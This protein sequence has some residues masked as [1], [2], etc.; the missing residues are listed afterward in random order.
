VLLSIHG[1]PAYQ[2]RPLYSMYNGL[3]QYLL[4]HGIAVLA[5]NIRGSAGYGLTYRQAVYRDWGGVDL[6]DLATVARYLRGQ[7][8][9]D[10]DRI[11]LLGASYGGFAVLSC[12]SRLAEI[13]WAAAVDMFG[14]ANLV[15][16]ADPNHR[17]GS[18]WSAPWSATTRPTRT[19][20]CHD[21]PSRTPTRSALRC[22]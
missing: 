14:P 19:S 6:Q 16:F 11:G 13:G 20:S 1:G 21:P 22:S 5:P 12:I 4:H 2:E 10:P 8:W 3:Y 15:T 9:V 7:D 17:R 18:R